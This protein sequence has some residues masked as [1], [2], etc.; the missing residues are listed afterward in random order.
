M[1]SVCECTLRRVITTFE[2]QVKTTLRLEIFSINLSW[3]KKNKFQQYLTRKGAATELPFTFP[4]LLTG[5]SDCWTCGNRRCWLDL[6][7]I[8][9]QLL[10]I[11]VCPADITFEK[12]QQCGCQQDETWAWLKNHLICSL[13]LTMKFFAAH[14]S[15]ENSCVIGW[16]CFSCFGMWSAA[17]LQQWSKAWQINFTEPDEEHD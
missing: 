12:L 1:T 17:R 9:S 10:E 2:G 14:S 11:F 5:S 6:N 16:W 4:P 3:I 7:H 13:I 15:T 8:E